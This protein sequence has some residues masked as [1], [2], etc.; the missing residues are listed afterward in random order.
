MLARIT[1][2]DYAGEVVLVAHAP[3]AEGLDP[4]I[5]LGR[6]HSSSCLH[7]SGNSRGDA[8]PELASV[9]GTVAVSPPLLCPHFT[10]TSEGF[11]P[12]ITSRTVSVARLGPA[13]LWILAPQR[14]GLLTPNQEGKGSTAHDVFVSPIRAAVPCGTRK[15]WVGHGVGHARFAIGPRFLFHCVTLFIQD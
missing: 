9:S 7:R 2:S 11:G 6:P 8:W 5:L 1:T 15:C 10:H 4:G 13:F 3:G 12:K 14:G